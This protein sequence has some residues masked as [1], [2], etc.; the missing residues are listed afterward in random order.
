M[1]L[2]RAILAEADVDEKVGST[3]KMIVKLKNDDGSV[4]GKYAVYFIKI[5]LRSKQD[6]LSFMSFETLLAVYFHELAHLRFMGHCKEFMVLLKHIYMFA[7][8]R[9]LFQLGKRNES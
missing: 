4:K 9:D 5:R 3:S 8:E 1:R 7:T 2:K 6:P